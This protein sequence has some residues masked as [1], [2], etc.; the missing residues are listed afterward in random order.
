[1]HGTHEN[2]FCTVHFKEVRAKTL[3]MEVPLDTAHATACTLSNGEVQH[4]LCQNGCNAPA[5]GETVTKC[6]Q[7]SHTL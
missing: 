1:M 7:T 5:S 6:Q 3:F 4:I 2:V